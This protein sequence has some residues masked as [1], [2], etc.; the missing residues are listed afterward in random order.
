MRMGEGVG[1][2]ASLGLVDANCYINGMDNEVLLYSTG[3]CVQSLEIEHD[4]G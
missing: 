3:M 2:T 1:W 4:R